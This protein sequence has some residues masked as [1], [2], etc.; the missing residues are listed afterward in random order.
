MD[1]LRRT[2]RVLDYIEDHLTDDIDYEEIGKISLCPS[3]L[4]QRV[5][6][7]LTGISLSEYIRRRKLSKAAMELAEGTESVLDVAIKYGYDSADAFTVA[8]KR[9]NG[10]TPSQAR[11]QGVELIHYPKLSFTMKIKGEL[12]MKYKMIKKPTFTVV[13]VSIQTTHDENMKNHSIPNFWTAFNAGK[14]GEKLCILAPDK[15]FLGV[16][17]GEKPDGTFRYMIGVE[18]LK[19]DKDLES[20]TIPAA[21]WAVFESIGPMPEAIMKVWGEIFQDFLPSGNYD[22]ADMPD[23]ES[24]PEANPDSD[25]YRCEVWIPVV[26][27]K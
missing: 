1:W 15:P 24:Y 8:F 7:T 4:F 5:F 13:G 10:I 22:H 2:N 26:P 16:C 18:S 9:V 20:L 23:F 11:E 21:N 25:H 14:T 27:K 6:S 3:G 19:T 12:K 17:Y